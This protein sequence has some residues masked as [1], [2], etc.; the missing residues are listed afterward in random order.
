[1]GKILTVENTSEV[2][3]NAGECTYVQGE[4]TE[5]KG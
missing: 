2:V 3:R 1:M 4:M 5:Q